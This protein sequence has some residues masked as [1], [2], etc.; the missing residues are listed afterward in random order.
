MTINL[1]ASPHDTVVVAAL[2]NGKANVID[3]AMI[4]ALHALIA[5]LDTTEALVLTGH[6]GMFTGGLDVGIVD[7]GDDQAR[8]LLAAMGRLLTTILQAPRPIVVAA[9]GHGIAAG[10][11][12]MLVA[13]HAIVSDRPAKYGFAE[14]PNGMALP[15]GVVELIAAKA[16]P[17]ATLRLAAHGHLA[18]PHEA[19]ELGLCHRVVPD[20]ELI[21]TAAD[22]AAVLGALPADAYATT[23][24]LV[25]AQLV[26]RMR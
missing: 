12:L 6:P 21:A 22:H 15:R 13:D 11:M 9:S 5:G 3:F 20:D 19:V 1:L 24:Q 8:A 16:N 2:D 26:E 18:T 17:Q 10:A 23:K 7:G 14:V 25:N 4:D